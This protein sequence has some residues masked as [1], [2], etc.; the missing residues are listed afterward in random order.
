MPVYVYTIY[1]DLYKDDVFVESLET[2][3]LATSVGEAKRLFFSE[4]RAPYEAIVTDI[5]RK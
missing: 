2:T 5:K 3:V 4:D 1:Y